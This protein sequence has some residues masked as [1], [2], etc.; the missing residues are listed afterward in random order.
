MALHGREAFQV[1]DVEEREGTVPSAGRHDAA[2]GMD[3]DNVDR[4]CRTDRSEAKLARLGPIPEE[5]RPVAVSG[6]QELGLLRMERQAV[7]AANPA[8][9]AQALATFP[10]VPDPDRLVEAG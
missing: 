8:A 2:A 5:E 7:N 1:I 9:Q 10:E 3:G 6:H 4:R